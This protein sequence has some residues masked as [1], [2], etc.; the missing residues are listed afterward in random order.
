MNKRE[1]VLK[2]IQDDIAIGYTLATSRLF[3]SFDRFHKFAENLLGEPISHCG[4]SNAFSN[5]HLWDRLR[6]KYEE[7]RLKELKG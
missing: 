4:L 1:E 3:I 6:K 7:K 2:E 5:K